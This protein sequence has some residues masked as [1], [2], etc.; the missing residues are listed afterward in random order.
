M[1]RKRPQKWSF[2][3]TENVRNLNLT[4]IDPLQRVIKMKRQIDAYYVCRRNMY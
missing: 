4:V 1:V 3:R 2:T